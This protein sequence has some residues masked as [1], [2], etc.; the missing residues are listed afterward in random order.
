[1]RDRSVVIRFLSVILLAALLF[2]AKQHYQ[3]P[4]DALEAWLFG[5]ASNPVTQAFASL[6]DSMEQGDGL[7]QVVQAFCEEK[8]DGAD[9]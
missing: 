7:G 1:M 5:E 3:K 8:S 4:A 6:S 9:S 2:F